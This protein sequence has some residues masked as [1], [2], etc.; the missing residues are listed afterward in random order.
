MSIQFGD[1]LKHNNLLYPIVDITDVKG[2][3][4][5][6]ATFSNPSLV[7]EFTSIPDKYK[8]GYTLLLETSTNKLYYLTGSDATDTSNWSLIGIS[9]VGAGI[10]NSLPKWTGTS[11]LGNSNISDSNN[12]VNIN[13]TL[14]VGTNSI[15]IGTAS[16]PAN[17]NISGK[18]N[19]SVDVTS[20]TF[21]ANG[22]IVYYGNGVGMTAGY[23]YALEK[24]TGNW[25]SAENKITYDC[26]LG[27]AL[28]NTTQFGLL[29]NGFVSSNLAWYS[30][31]TT[32]QPQYLGNTASVFQNVPPSG[33][34]A[35]QVR[36]IGYA[37]G[38][39]PTTNMIYFNPD[40]I[41][42]AQSIH[43]TTI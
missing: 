30:N 13:T 19:Y 9:G 14:Q 29:I 38:N 40:N 22:Q 23:I 1:I 3:V 2:G 25:V 37:V 27:I 42:L 20:T 32:G 39:S 17:I 21:S 26:Q 33:G 5:S 8:T 41:W 6:I 34:G 31:M 11:T 36:I 16:T 4:R 18:L 15:S 10:T 43:N 24:G 35:L 12:I 7:S 28:G